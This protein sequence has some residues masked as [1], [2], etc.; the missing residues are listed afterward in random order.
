MIKAL[1]SAVLIVEMFSYGD[2]KVA[3]WQQDPIL[4]VH[5]ILEGLSK[6]GTAFVNNKNTS[7]R[8]RDRFR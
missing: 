7:Y 6:N 2:V 1:N 3:E 5:V 4:V 8:N